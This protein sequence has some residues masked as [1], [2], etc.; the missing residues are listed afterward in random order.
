MEGTEMGEE[1]GRG[2]IRTQVTEVS[3]R[4]DKGEK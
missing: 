4:S 1:N 2:D 3:H